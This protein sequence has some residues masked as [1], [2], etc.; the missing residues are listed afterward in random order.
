MTTH[1]ETAP[2]GETQP[3]RAPHGLLPLVGRDPGEASRSGSA[4]ELI[5]DL[6]AVVA[7]SIAASNLEHLLSEGHIVQGVG[8]FLF[9]VFGITWA[10]STY[11]QLLSAFDTDD[12]G[13]RL[14]T[15]MQM[16]GVLVLALGISPMVESVDAGETLNNQIM[17]MGY[18]VMRVGAII[19]W[20][21]VARASEKYRRMAMSYVWALVISQVGWCLQA[22]LPLSPQVGLVVMGV[23]LLQEVLYPIVA[24]RRQAMPWH[25]H[26][27]GERLGAFVIITLGEVVL[28]TLTAVQADVAEFGWTPGAIAVG[29]AG[30][31]LAFG[32]WW[33]YFILPSGDGL[34]ARPS[35][36]PVVILLHILLYAC[37]A[38][39]GAGL[40]LSATFVE[41]EGHVSLVG[42]ALS[43]AIPTM[44]AI[45]LIFTLFHVFLPGF[46]ALHVGLLVGS[47]A[48][49]ILG[50]GLAAAGA[51]LGVVV[52]VLM[53]VPWVSVIGYEVRG[54][55]TLTSRVAATRAALGGSARR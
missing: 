46:D 50:V 7:V 18:V 5:F 48:V 22:F 21:R 1:A 32:L 51:P 40:H 42:A 52:V 20:L 43:V 10:W 11:S 54:H 4:L 14:V 17:V 33:V 53:L 27:L 24:E 30:L 41:G 38:A 15:L 55:R 28:G 19:L 13:V 23:W 2:D 39:I 3:Q 45:V 6:V 26:H 35:R 29:A 8:T 31:S 44:L 49:A 47:A 12:W 16:F 34:D 36:L 9:A 25:P 37:V